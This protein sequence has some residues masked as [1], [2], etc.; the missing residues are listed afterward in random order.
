MPKLVRKD[1]KKIKVVKSKLSG[2]K[3]S[4]L[5]IPNDY[6]LDK[7]G[8]TQSMIQTY[9]DCRVKF[10]YNINKLQAGQSIERTLFGTCMHLG[11]EWLYKTSVIDVALDT[12]ERKWN[13]YSN[14]L[15]GVKRET[16]M[17]V[18]ELTCALLPIY[19]EV[20]EKEIKEKTVS[21]VEKEFE[22][23][24]HNALL[25]G[26]IDGIKKETKG[27]KVIDHKTMSRVVEGSLMLKLSFDFQMMFYAFCAK[28][29]HPVNGCIYNVIRKPA[30]KQKKTESN[31][32]YY[33][34]ILND[35]KSRPD[36]YFFRYPITFTKQDFFKFEIELRNI[37]DEIHSFLHGNISIF[38]N[39][40]S[41]MTFSQ[42]EFL[43]SCAK[44]SLIGLH[45]KEKMFSELDH[46]KY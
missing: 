36:F 43:E 37:L 42:C 19:Y 33:D 41:C 27:Y 5:K 32:D 25:R 16:V 6:K 26:K 31:K 18:F 38:K 46:C 22:T 8:I 45:N 1:K 24:F 13:I 15:I 29:F 11:L 17:G 28:S 30:L 14:S 20:Y 9:L 4:D 10:L 7:N 44:Q 12:L 40:R 34:R 39:G 35:I 3:L 21:T 23:P 2:L